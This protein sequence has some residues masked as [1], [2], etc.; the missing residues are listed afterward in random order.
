MKKILSL[1]AVLLIS[2]GASAQAEWDFSEISSIDL[3]DLNNDADNWYYDSEKDRYSFQK[4]LTEQELTANGSTFAFTQGLFFTAPAIAEGKTKA[5]GERHI[6]DVAP[7]SIIIRT[8]WLYSPHGKNFVKT[9]L[10]LGKEKEKLRVVCD[11]VGTPTYA[12]DLASIVKTFIDCEEWHPGIYHFSNEG[13]ISWYDFTLAIHRIAGI[14]TCH[15]LP[16]MT[17]DYPTPATRP[18]YSVL[19]KTKIK[20]TLGIEIPHWEESL[21]QCI[22]ILTTD[23]KI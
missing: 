21:E 16:C 9:M 23:N 1:L 10:A 5:D 4:A 7:E 22:N 11:Q 13:A 12:L 20:S 6:M 19:D 17:K 3:S 8:A 14:T 2:L 15:V 18:H